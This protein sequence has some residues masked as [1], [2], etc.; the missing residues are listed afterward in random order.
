M[1]QVILPRT[2]FFFAKETLIME[3]FYEELKRYYLPAFGWQNGVT[4]GSFGRWFDDWEAENKQTYVF[5]VLPTGGQGSLGY[6]GHYG[7]CTH[8]YDYFLS[9]KN[10]GVTCYIY[11]PLLP[12]QDLKGGLVVDWREIIYQMALDYMEHSHDDDYE[13]VLAKNNPE[14]IY[15]VTGYE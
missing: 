2:A 6:L 11:K 7:G 12:T 1:K 4:T 3:N 15:G 10:F 14:F 5:D 8:D 13:I 9:L